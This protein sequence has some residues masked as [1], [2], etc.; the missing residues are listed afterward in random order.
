MPQQTPSDRS[1]ELRQFGSVARQVVTSHLVLVLAVTLVVGLLIGWFLFG[2]VIAPVE[3]T[4][5]KPASLSEQYQ[6]VLISYA[7]DSYFSH[8]TPIED[9]AKRLGEGWTKKQV[10]SQ[11][12]Q[13]ISENRPGIDRLNFLKS[14][15]QNYPHEI[16]PLAVPGETPAPSAIDPTLLIAAVVVLAGAAL[17]GWLVVSR[18]RS[19]QSPAAEGTVDVSGLPSAAP[20]ADETQPMPSV[21]R[22]PGGARPVDAPVVIGESRKPLVQ[23]TTTYLAGDDRYDMSFSIETAAGDFLGE[24]GVGIGEVVGSGV[25]D[26][27]TALEV[28]LFDKND[29]RTLTKILMSDFCFGDSTL[30]AKLL[31]KGEAAQIKKGDAIE[32]KTQS[33]RV[34]ARIID[35]VYGEASAKDNIAA[36]SYF[37]KVEIELA[38]WNM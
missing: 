18:L 21:G 10:I 17:V 26:K 19:V 4:A 29:I 5:T 20:R 24:C 16:G 22:A 15:L 1:P 13:M 8:Y 34:T 36:N 30:K 38:A 14:G 32:L 11:I 12:D 2:W 7:A 37:Q 9:I 28:W 25:P 27:V 3:Y 33:L 6:K 35:L 23:Y 31:P